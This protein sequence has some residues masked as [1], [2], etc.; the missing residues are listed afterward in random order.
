MSIKKQDLPKDHSLAEYTFSIDI[1]SVYSI[2]DFCGSGHYGTVNKAFLLA[3]PSQ[4]FAVKR[5][6]K[7]FI[8]NTDHL[9]REVD[10]LCTLHHPNIIKIYETYQDMHFFYIVMQYC[11]GGTLYSRISG[12]KVTEKK[13][14]KL[15]KQVIEALFYL[16]AKG[17]CHRDIKPENFLFSSE[18]KTAKL[19]LID[20][21]LSHKLGKW[22]KGMNDL[23]GT[24]YY[25][26]PEVIMGKYTE[27]CDNWSVGVIMYLLLSGELPFQGTSE[28]QI[29]HKIL[30]CEVPY[31]LESW[32][33]VSAQGRDLVKRLLC[34]NP[35]E[36]ISVAQAYQHPWL[37]LQ[38][39]PGK[40]LLHDFKVYAMREELVLNLTNLVI[41]SLD[42][43]CI[44]DIF[45]RFCDVERDLV[46]L[47]EFER[48]TRVKF[49]ESNTSLNFS[50][51]KVLKGALWGK[52]HLNE[53]KL[54]K[55]FTSYDLEKTGKITLS[56]L[57]EI[58]ESLEGKYSR[59]FSSVPSSKI[60]SF[61][62]VM[63][64]YDNGKL[65]TLKSQSTHNN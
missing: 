12:K 56:G 2:G 35:Q 32:K 33:N 23:V 60:L 1:K 25:I 16:Q 65:L 7:E 57:R 59:D 39:E 8:R 64:F 19:V 20:F 27:K 31:F 22:F 18:K 40:E 10:I 6:S 41:N 21:G 37:Q 44:E 53:E 63:R 43:S 54:W 46:D 61:A 28:S 5:I 15:I 58:S 26:A 38:F 62:D 36:R 9:R 42:Y 11:S 47:I 14:A 50:F 29:I 52:L 55:A 34:K 3:D 24:V 4:S 17:I 48:R 30:H 45:K 49:D 51:K 13:A